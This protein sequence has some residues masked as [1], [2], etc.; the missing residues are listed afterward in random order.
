MKTLQH[1]GGKLQRQHRGVE[2]HAIGDFEHDRMWVAHDEGMPDAVRPSQIEHEGDANQQISQKG[3]QDRRPHNRLQPFQIENMYRGSQRESSGRQHHAAQYVEADPQPPGKLICQVGSSPQPLSKAQHRRVDSRGHQKQKR[4]FPEGELSFHWTFLWASVTPPSSRD[5][6]AATSSR[7]WVIH[8]TPPSKTPPNGTMSGI[9]D[10]TRYVSMGS[11][12]PGSD[13][14]YPN[15]SKGTLDSS[16]TDV[17]P[18][19]VS[20]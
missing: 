20:P 4:E 2:H 15:S 10:N 12:L 7:R 18:T 11:G 14:R 1:D 16:S 19:S 13:A 5:S 8:Q 3:R 17:P 6:A 9:R